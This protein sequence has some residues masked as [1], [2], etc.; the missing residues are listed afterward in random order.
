M[1]INVVDIYDPWVDAAEAEHEY[2][3]TPVAERQ[4]GGYDA[5][6][7]AAGHRQFVELDGPSVRAFGKANSVVFDVKYVLPRD[8]VDG[9][10]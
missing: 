10:L 5:I 6:I 8:A 4:S 2:G 1:T 3:L 9:R 7:L